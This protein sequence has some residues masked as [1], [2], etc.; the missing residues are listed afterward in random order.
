[1][2]LECPNCSV[3][4]RVSAEALGETGRTVRCSRCAFEWFAEPR[5]LKRGTRSHVEEHRLVAES[6][7][8]DQDISV[9]AAAESG[10]NVGDFLAAFEKGTDELS[11]KREEKHARKLAFSRVE[12]VAIAVSFLLFL[13]G[14]LAY[15]HEPLG[16]T[17]FAG[18]YSAVGM[19][20]SEGV[21]LSGL[22]LSKIAF[23]VKTRY[24]IQGSVVNTSAREQPIPTLRI[25]LV[26]KQGK[27]LKGWEFIPKKAMMQPREVLPLNP[28][29]L[30]SV[31]Q[32]SEHAFLVDIGSGFDMTLRD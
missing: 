8:P 1:M 17:G 23:G 24:G 2:L 11:A 28:V 25:R 16:K 12:W 31:Y 20:K 32:E 4:F 14:S 19:G 10:E 26:D 22:R 13:V 29:A 6:L 15:F 7:A 27:L 5:D 9:A 3:N 21:K 30:D 18:L